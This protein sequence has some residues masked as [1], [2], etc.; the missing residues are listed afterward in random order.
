MSH[1]EQA[2]HIGNVKIPVANSPAA[3]VLSEGHPSINRITA[4]YSIPAARIETPLRRFANLAT[5][6]SALPAYTRRC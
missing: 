3:L 6:P 1:I 2:G 4:C 5:H